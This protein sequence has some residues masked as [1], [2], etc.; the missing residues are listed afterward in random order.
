MNTSRLYLYT[1]RYEWVFFSNVTIYFLYLIQATE[2]SYESERKEKPFF[3]FSLTLKPRG[4]Q[5]FVI[6]DL[7]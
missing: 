2:F 7:F 3:F 5:P 1:Y 6:H 4:E